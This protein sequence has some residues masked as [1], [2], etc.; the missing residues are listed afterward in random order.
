MPKLAKL[1][2]MLSSPNDGEVVN[3]ARLLLKAAKEQ[4]IDLAELGRRI[5]NRPPPRP[6]NNPPPKPRKPPSR[7]PDGSRGDAIQAAW[8][9]YR[10]TN[11]GVRDDTANG[12][13]KLLVQATALL[14][15]KLAREREQGL[16]T[17][18]MY[19]DADMDNLV[20][21][22]FDPTDGVERP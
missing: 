18:W 9:I 1:L 6:R 16:P 22:I 5:E 4:G 3:A 20:D 19:T 2:A 21:M 17:T 11:P 13:L 12:M 7:N 15:W 14:E 10:R 8:R